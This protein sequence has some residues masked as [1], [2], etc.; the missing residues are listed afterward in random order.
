M[1]MQL[2]F[3]RDDRRDILSL[4]LLAVGC[5]FDKILLGPYA[6]VD[7]YDAIEVHFAH[8][9]HMAEFW[10]Q[11]GA[12]SWYPFHAGGVPSFV[13]QHPPYNPAVFLSA[14][15][16]IWV[17]ALVWNIGQMFL[18]GYGVYRFLQLLP[19]CSRQT[20]L[21]C[22]ALSSLALVS[23]NVHMVMSYAFPAVFVWTVDMFRNAS[24]R[25]LRLRNAL[26]ILFV[27]LLSFPVLSLPHFPVLHLALVLFLGRHLPDF[28]RQIAGVFLVWTGYV[29][30]F[31]PSITSLF[32]YIPFAQRDWDF[33]YA[34][35]LPALLDFG[36]WFLGRMSDQP[37][38][39]G[40]LLG[41]P[42]LR[43]RDIRIGLLFYLAM[44]VVAGAF[45]SELKAL[46]AGSFLLKMDLFMFTT[47]TGAVSVI[48]AGLAVDE[49]G[50]DKTRLAPWHL[51]PALLAL[52]LLGAAHKVIGHVLVLGVLVCAILLLRRGRVGLPKPRQA[53]V[54]FALVAC[55]A[56]FGMMTRQRNMTAGLF[57]PYTKG[58]VG[59]P[60]LDRLA[61]AAKLSPF[62]VACVDVHPAII[63]SRGLDTVG[64]K[65]PLF[66]K[67]FKEYVREAVRPQLPT[68]KDVAD[69]DALW[70][71]LYLT[72]TRKDHDQRSY[73]LT[74][75]RPRSAA[76]LNWNL[77]RAMNVTHVVAA[78]PIEGMEPFAGPP[79]LS[80]GLAQERPWLASVGLGS[81]HDLPLWIYA[82]KEA[83]A[84]VRLALPRVMDTRE[85]V[86]RSL[87]A[88]TAQEL[89]GTAFLAREDVPEGFSA[90]A[91]GQDA[92]RVSLTSWGPDVLR[93]EGV[94]AGPCVLVVSNN[95][96]PRWQAR[97]DGVATPVFRANHAFQGLRIDRA[98]PFCVELRFGSPLIWW[99]HLATGA[100]V[101]LLLCA[102]WRPPVPASGAVPGPALLPPPPGPLE[103]SAWR[104]LA[105]SL[106]MA[107]A[108]MLA[109]VL[110]VVPKARGPE[111][112]SMPYALATIPLMG[113]IIGQWARGLVRKL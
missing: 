89:N 84:R 77:L 33:P 50:A 85:E 113:L 22:A 44:H 63:Q 34:G 35:L 49:Y 5:Y 56:G 36:R 68:D 94:A 73:V 28:K 99:L 1:S 96:D 24:P 74:P 105:P 30:I 10:A 69:F 79:E 32:L 21:V 91:P 27:G 61:A 70:H 31:L 23:G 82:L 67:Y 65:S 90:V 97:V 66:N 112:E 54:V 18:L 57:V 86:L 109:F 47:A 81:L 17:L 16:P 72:R 88:A 110:F 102:L 39:M 106:V 108:W 48:I 7:F 80:P 9:R 19:R 11:H 2:P 41:A 62:R 38:L 100:G 4:L 83:Q 95:F 87:G 55:L 26:L 42:L 59:H 101:L 60:A 71:Q 75:A 92:G 104:C 107:S 93:M 13:G 58:F 37:L 3:W 111:A 53:W 98:G 14:L 43:R 45:S 76:D 25:W 6:V 51:A 78:G 46:F 29:L 20:A 15:M 64:G 8:F 52:P 40:V 103:I 12:F